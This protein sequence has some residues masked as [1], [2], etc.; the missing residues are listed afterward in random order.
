MNTIEIVKLDNYKAQ[1]ASLKTQ[2]SEVNEDLTSKIQRRDKLAEELA[3]LCQKIE[4][5]HSEREKIARSVSDSLAILAD[6]QTKFE[7]RQR[8]VEERLDTKER[9]LDMVAHKM[10]QIQGEISRDLESKR[11][12]I[13]ELKE[14]SNELLDKKVKL[15]SDLKELDKAINQSRKDESRLTGKIDKLKSEYNDLERDYK[16]RMF[17]YTL[18]LG[19]IEKK[20]LAQKSTIDKPIE[21]LKQREYQFNEAVRR[22]NTLIRRHRQLF[23]KYFPKIGLKLDDFR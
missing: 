19:E 22:Y 9:H 8:N 14:I 13:A 5:A 7:E 6:R 18:E 17:E 1:L 10:A 20:V 15:L 11:S 12:L 23:K 21:Y 16:K 4:D 2:A 3:V